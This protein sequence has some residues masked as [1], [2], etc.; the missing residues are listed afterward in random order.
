MLGGTWR[1]RRILCVLLLSVFACLLTTR[2][3]R[4]D[5]VNG[6]ERFNGTNYDLTTWEGHYTL[7]T[8]IQWNDAM[9]FD[10][11]T[12]P[13]VQ[14]GGRGEMVTV[15]P[16]VGVG[17]FVEAEVTVFGFTDISPYIALRLS[18]KTN[19]NNSNLDSHTVET[20]I[21]PSDSYEAIN[22]TQTQ[23]GNGVGYWVSPPGTMSD[24]VNKTYILRI[25][26]PS[27]TVA[28]MSAFDANHVQIGTTVS[29][30][31]SGFP[32]DMHVVVYA[33]EAAARFD[34]VRIGTL[35]EPSAAAATLGGLALAALRRGRRP[36]AA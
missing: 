18:T 11:R 2:P 1:E 30:A 24:I 31:L 34:N 12:I 14:G 22:G 6:V 32:D 8:F 13:G 28:R 29:Q 21:L 33:G 20:V 16:L 9:Y 26:R 35:P 23:N 17:E 19:V 36:A 27:S 25:D 7:G 4:A 15:D 10:N 5:F 3:A